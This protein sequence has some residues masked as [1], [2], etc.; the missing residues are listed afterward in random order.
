MKKII[1]HILKEK[2]IY[3]DK[4]IDDLDVMKDFSEKY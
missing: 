2:Y 1:V 4:F 3:E